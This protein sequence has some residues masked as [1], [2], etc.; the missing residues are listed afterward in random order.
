MPLVDLVWGGERAYAAAGVG[1][2]AAGAEG[3]SGVASVDGSVVM[4]PNV[5]GVVDERTGRL[6]VSVALASLA[7]RGA[8]GGGGASLTASWD[9]QL[10]TSSEAD[11]FGLGAGW[12]LGTAFVEVG[13]GD[14]RSRLFT[15]TGGSFEIASDEDRRSGR[16]GDS[17]LLRYPL[18]DIVFAQE[19]G[20]LEGRDGVKER[21]YAFTLVAADGGRQWFS[22]QGDLLAVADRFGN[23][24]DYVW[25]TGHTLT[26][27]VDGYGQ[28]IGL[29]WADRADGQGREFVVRG[30]ERADGEVPV[31]RLVPGGDGWLEKVIDPAGEET[32]FAP[33]A[34]PGGRGTVLGQVISAQ[35]AVTDIAYGEPAP[36]VVA[37][38]SVKVSAGDGTRLARELTLDMNPS[39]NGQRNFTG[40]G[41]DGVQPDPDGYGLFDSGADDYTYET[42][43]SDGRSSVR[44]VFNRAHLVKK[45]TSD[46][47]GLGVVGRME[48]AYPGEDGQGRPPA[49]DAL[50]ANYAQAS[51]T[52]STVVDP[53]DESRSRPVTSLAEYDE[54]GRPVKTVER[55]GSDTESVTETVYDDGP[56][57]AGG[58]YGLP[59]KTTVTGKD[60][61]RTETVFELTG[62]DGIE[63]V[64][65]ATGMAVKSSTAYAPDSAGRLAGRTVV[66]LSTDARG[67]TTGQRVTWAEGAKPEGHEGP[68]AYETRSAYEVKPGEKGGLVREDTTTTVMD[69]DEDHLVSTQVTDLSGGLALTATD[70]GGRVGRQ[71]YDAAGRVVSATVFAGTGKELTS[72]VEYASPTKVI[73]TGPDGKRTITEG[74]ALGRTTRVSDNIRDGRIIKDGGDGARVLQQVDYQHALDDA[75][76]RVITT[77]AAGLVTETATDRSGTVSDTRA[78][79][80]TVSRT[81]ADLVANTSASGLLASGVE[82]GNGLESARAVAGR[83]ADDA[84]RI[85]EAHTVF[86]DTALPAPPRATT[87]YDGLGRVRTATA[88]DLVTTPAYGTGGAQTGTSMR[89]AQDSPYQGKT[90]TAEQSLDLSGGPLHKILTQGEGEDAESRGG[91]RN[92]LDL[93]GRVRVQVDQ[94]GNTTTLVHAKDGQIASSVTRTPGRDGQDG[95]LVSKTSNTYDQATGRPASTTVT[96]GQGTETTRSMRYDELGRVTEVWEGTP[97]D[98]R[99][100]TEQYKASV[101]GYGY[102][103]DG[104]TTSVTYPDGTTLTQAFDK[105]GRLTT[106]TDAAGAVTDYTYHAGTGRLEKAVQKAKDG[107]EL[108]SAAYGYD[109]L[110]RVESIAHGNK[111]TTRY[112][113]FDNDQPKTQTLAKDDGGEV[114]ARTAYT[115]NSHGNLESRTDTRP[116]VKDDGTTDTGGGNVTTHTVHT[117]DAYDRLIRTVLHDGD[118]AQGKLVKQTDYTINASG[119]IT[120]TKTTSPDGKISETVNTIDAAG[121]R[122]TVTLDSAKAEQVWDA[123]GNLITDR[124]GTTITY[125][126]DN[127]PTTLTPTQPGQATV[128]VAYWA[129]GSRRSATTTNGEGAQ[130]T[131]TYHYTPTGTLANDT[132]AGLTA[133]YLTTPQGREHR[134]LTQDGTPAPDTAGTGYLH[135][136]R[137]GNTTALTD[138]EGAVTDSYYYEDYGRPTTHHTT[139]LTPNP[140]ADRAHTNPIQYGGEYTNNWDHTQ[141]TPAR[142]YTPDGYFTT[143]DTWQLHNRH[144][145]FNTDPVNHTDPSG[146]L[147]LSTSTK[148]V[149]G[150]FSTFAGAGM[151]AVGATSAATD[152]LNIGTEGE[153]ALMGTGGASLAGGAFLFHSAHQGKL[154]RSRDTTIGNMQRENQELTSANAELHSANAALHSEKAAM[155]EEI[156]QLKKDNANMLNTIQSLDSARVDRATMITRIRSFHKGRVTHDLLGGLVSNAKQLDIEITLLVND[157]TFQSNFKS[158]QVNLNAGPASYM[159]VNYGPE[160]M[161]SIVKLTALEQVHAALKQSHAALKQGGI[162]VKGYSDA[163][164]A[165]RSAL[166]KELQIG[167]PAMGHSVGVHYDGELAVL[168][169]YK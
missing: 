167:N 36:G 68:D 55:A 29:G 81:V 122:T 37:V 103:A 104:N 62:K 149:A 31:T 95:T 166:W 71:A 109:S 137:R 155:A 15:D 144:Q 142:T 21:E 150:A 152:A 89:P 146:H 126:P 58:H 91:T 125:N 140:Q 61:T 87:A 2:A 48:Y 136:D 164:D 18:K 34:G 4:G 100:K 60:G 93:A 115:Y 10:L 24:T 119:D 157:S 128:A 116:G 70:P 20:K 113:Y 162:V 133:S 17:G 168:F 5:S 131:T 42:V 134:T 12:S 30:P 66:S 57:G 127:K 74:D 85:T 84:G 72:T 52:V 44:S 43:L 53:G 79:D 124:H 110:G 22:A 158:M 132:T 26:G 65:D 138:H 139:P 90:F 35:G 153:M 105:A 49:A 120:H 19:T 107:T 88:G 129:D 67:E 32:R 46:I 16:A 27:V 25:Q 123:A 112:E 135:T 160:N 47:S 38:E 130:Q 111:T 92:V 148:R 50:P 8:A 108:A 98:G 33:A 39:G 147:S 145:A 3:A 11:R 64:E 161:K 114:L 169:P 1:R 28:T 159:H 154:L 41:A 97:E 141:Y 117:Y 102:N 13:E 82:A 96:D 118:S 51:R 163:L 86:A 156:S 14:K 7:G 101:I 54:R 63:G 73:V 23:R 6:G 40:T 59:V 56:V 99:D 151:L 76:P 143:R 78:A 80:G 77:D 69:R 94:L 9:Q 45:Q 165:S 75:R 121:R 106:S 83:K